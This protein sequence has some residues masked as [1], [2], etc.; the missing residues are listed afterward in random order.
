M[1]PNWCSVHTWI[2][3]VLCKSTLRAFVSP[4]PL[5]FFPLRAFSFCR[6]KCAKRLWRH[7]GGEEL[8]DGRAKKIKK[9]K[10]VTPS[11]RT[12]TSLATVAAPKT[13]TRSA[14]ER[15]FPLLPSKIHV[16][17]AAL[18]SSSLQDTC[19]LLQCLIFEFGGLYIKALFIPLSVVTPITKKTFLVTGKAQLSL[20][21]FNNWHN[22]LFSDWKW[23]EISIMKN[24]HDFKKKSWAFT[25]NDLKGWKNP[26]SF[27]NSGRIFLTSQ[28][29]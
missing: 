14:K 5:S 4:P 18:P 8:V 1:R 17:L 12:W 20:K 28:F 22:K 7:F 27:F 24:F 10:E 23:D 25:E 15:K 6:R 19:V 2:K 9:F 21:K 13:S 16:P 3:L 29:K 26:F 11:T